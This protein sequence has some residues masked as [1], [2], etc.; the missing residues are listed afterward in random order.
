MQIES[1]KTYLVKTKGNENTQKF[2]KLNPD[3]TLK[4]LREKLGIKLE[5]FF[6]Q[7]KE[8]ILPKDEINLTIRDIAIKDVIEL[9]TSTFRQTNFE[10]PFDIV[11]I[12]SYVN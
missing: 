8:A 6:Y 12:D 7:D 1:L 3:L 9:S 10:D 5:L 4:E 2:E 11:D